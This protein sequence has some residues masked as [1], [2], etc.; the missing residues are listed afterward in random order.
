MLCNGTLPSSS[1]QA[2]SR[3]NVFGIFVALQLCQLT[4]PYGSLLF[5]GVRGFLWHCNPISSFV[6]ACIIYL[7]ATWVILA[8]IPGSD[9]TTDAR[10]G[11]NTVEERHN[12][13]ALR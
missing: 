7:A 6:E 1:N 9:T 8:G 10:S 12:K 2:F 13:R 5:R 3:A 4:Q 11:V